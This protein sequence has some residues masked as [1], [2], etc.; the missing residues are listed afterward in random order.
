MNNIII[1]K[2]YLLLLILLI[3]C[4]DSKIEIK[5]NWQNANKNVPNTIEFSEDGS[6]IAKIQ[7]EISSGEEIKGKTSDVIDLGF[8]LIKYSKGEIGKI[9]LTKEDLT[10]IDAIGKFIPSD[11]NNKPWTKVLIHTD[12]EG[13]IKIIE[14]Y[15][16]Q[17]IGAFQVAPSMPLNLLIT[18]DGHDIKINGIEFNVEYMDKKLQWGGTF[19][20]K[21]K[22]IVQKNI[23]GFVP[24]KINN[25]N[26]KLIIFTANTKGNKILLNGTNLKIESEQY[27]KS[28]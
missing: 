19:I 8:N 4:S 16:G 24:I 13:N 22:Y 25:N 7:Y 20:I 21:G 18:I 11:E 12:K 15:Q 5:G 14:E 6:F 28:K 23:E 17:K 10:Q 27:S 9:I 3:G 26:Y 1:K 2:M